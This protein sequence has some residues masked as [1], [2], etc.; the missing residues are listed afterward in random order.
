MTI[1]QVC[2]REV[3]IAYPETTVAEA[4][5]LMREYHV[6]DVVIVA[7]PEGKRAPLGIVTDRD[8]VV[9][10]LARQAP[11]AGLTV[12]E[13]TVQD[14]VSARE[15]EGVFE[16]IELM[17]FKGVRRMPIVDG[18]GSLVGIVSMDDLLEILAEELEAL[19]KLISRERAVEQQV[20]K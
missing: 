13:I 15:D 2:T 3:I 19:I 4:A 5:R 17:R 11:V 18:Q 1:G 9:E 12:G 20:R 6:G 14:L 10:V 16:S 8:L 7:G